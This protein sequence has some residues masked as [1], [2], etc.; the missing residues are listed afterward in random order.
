[1]GSDR[2]VDAAGTRITAR[3]S[4]VVY[5]YRTGIAWRDWPERFGPWQTVRK[6][7]HRFATDGTWDKLLAVLQ[8]DAAGRLAW[9]LSVD[10]SIV[11][12]H[13]HWPRPSGGT[14][15]GRASTRGLG[16]MTRILD[17]VSMSLASRPGPLPRRAEHEDPRRGRRARSAAGPAAHPRSG[18][19]RGDD[20]AATGDAADRADPGRP[21]TRPERVLADK[22][23]PSRAI[24]THLRARAITAVIPEQS[25]QADHRRAPGSAGGRPVS[26]DRAA[27]RGR[28][29]IER[30]CNGFKHWRGLAT[31]Y[32][33]EDEPSPTATDSSSPQP[34]A[35]SP[36]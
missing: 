11:Q 21:R 17:A 25:T 16:R 31:R 12:A 36:T 15:R 23:Y 27:Y 8:A 3:L 4:G 33:C 18:R 35:G 14:A 1:M 30:A 19:R 28:N 24:R 5:R 29:V 6:R 22:A 9:N 13:Q 2:A 20:S 26:F 34:S 10:S 7:R 32:D